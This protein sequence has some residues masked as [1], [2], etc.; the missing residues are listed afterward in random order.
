MHG[1]DEEMCTIILV[2]NP[3]WK[4]L[5]G[6]SRYDWEGNFKM[7]LKETEYDGVDSINQVQNK[8]HWWSVVNTAI[9]L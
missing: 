1:R 8:V 3:E 7:N 6:R 9:S 5:L 2:R 4:R